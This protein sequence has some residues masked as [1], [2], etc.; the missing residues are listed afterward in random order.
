MAEIRE[1][2]LVVD[3]EET[4]RSLIKQI[5][6]D[7]GYDVTTAANGEE[8][9]NILS[10]QKERSPDLVIL[11]IMMPGLNGLEVLDIIR[12]RFDIPVIMLTAKQAVT[13]VRDAPLLV[14]MTT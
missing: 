14:Q 5:M 3:D 4:I 9:L 13:T 8:A 12:G 11:D 1:R 2:V 6:Q 7:A 10:Q